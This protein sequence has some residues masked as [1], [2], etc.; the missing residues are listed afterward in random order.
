MAGIMAGTISKTSTRLQCHGAPKKETHYTL[1]FKEPSFVALT[2]ERIQRL[3]LF[4]TFF[5][6]PRCPFANTARLTNYTQIV[7]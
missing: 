7:T 3:S 5:P 2:I 1:L 4:Y 6:L